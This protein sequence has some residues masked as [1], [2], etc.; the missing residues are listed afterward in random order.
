VATAY[1]YLG[2]SITG[3]FLPDYLFVRTLILIIIAVI[4]IALFGRG[5]FYV[6]RHGNTVD[7]LLNVAMLIVFIILWF[8]PLFV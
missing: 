3:I 8:F 5:V 4:Y 6:I 7:I 1:L 2:Y